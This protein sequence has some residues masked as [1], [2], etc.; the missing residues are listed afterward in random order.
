MTRQD[1]AKKTVGIQNNG[2]P[3]GVEEPVANRKGKEKLTPT[4]RTRLGR[5]AAFI[6]WGIETST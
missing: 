1:C 3:E 4:E 6:R 2:V 5:K